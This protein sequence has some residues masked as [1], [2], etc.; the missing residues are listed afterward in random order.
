MFLL[1]MIDMKSKH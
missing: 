1:A